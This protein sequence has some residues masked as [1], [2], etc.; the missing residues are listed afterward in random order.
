MFSDYDANADGVL[1]QSEFSPFYETAYTSYYDD[2]DTDADGFLSEDEYSTGLYGAADRDSN[3]R[4]SIEEE[5]FFEG[6]FDGD[7][8]TAEVERV[9]PVY[10]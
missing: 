8:I 10:N 6:W 2:L 7:D 3:L 4:V 1:D 5:G 9:G